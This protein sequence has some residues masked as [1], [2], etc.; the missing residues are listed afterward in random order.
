MSLVGAEVI[1][2]VGPRSCGPL[3]GGSLVG[4]EV[5][6]LVERRSCGPLV[7]AGAPPGVPAVTV[8]QLLCLPAHI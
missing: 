4:A 2:L 8:L 7:G 5:L 3:V 1:V 6:V